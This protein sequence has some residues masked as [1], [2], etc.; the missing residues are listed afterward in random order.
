MNRRRAGDCPHLFPLPQRTQVDMQLEP[1]RCLTETSALVCLE[2]LSAHSLT[3]NQ[4]ASTPALQPKVKYSSKKEN[5]YAANYKVCC[6]QSAGHIR[7]LL[8]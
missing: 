7:V 1:P 6:N 4:V 3:I 2:K 5:N 8:C